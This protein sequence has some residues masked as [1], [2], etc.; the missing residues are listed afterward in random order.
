MEEN[1]KSI[2]DDN[3]NKPQEGTWNDMTPTGERKPK[4]EFEIGKSVEVTFSPDFE[5]PRELPSSGKGVYYIFDC[6]YKG[7][8]YIF[9]TA[10]WS[11]LQG[12]KNAEPLRGKTVVISKSMKDGKQHYEVEDL[13]NP[14]VPVEKIG[15]A[16]E[17]DED[18]DDDEDEE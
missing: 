2:M 18:S 11:M 1:E 14:E 3:A 16:E 12:L 5:K 9:M 8:E 15:D 7:E 10:A 4:I 17:D 13:S 6:I